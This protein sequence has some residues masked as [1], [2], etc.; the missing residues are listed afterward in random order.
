VARR[1]ESG[2]GMYINSSLYFIR[3]YLFSRY[4]FRILSGNNVFILYGRPSCHTLSK[5]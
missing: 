5:A 4:D 2:E 3:K 1:I